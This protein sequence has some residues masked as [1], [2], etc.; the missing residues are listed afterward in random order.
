MESKPLSRPARHRKYLYA[1]ALGMA[2]LII[3]TLTAPLNSPAIIVAVGFIVAA[4]DIWVI[5]H[6]LMRAITLFLPQNKLPKR[7]LTVALAGFGIVTL[8]LASLGQLTWRDTLVVAVITVIGYLYSLRFK[9]VPKT[10]G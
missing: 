3:F 2:N 9:L 1:V 7:R 8:A 10:A 5:V 6:L 4:L